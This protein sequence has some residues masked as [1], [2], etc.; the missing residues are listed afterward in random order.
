MNRCSKSAENRAR[1]VP[2]V[3]SCPALRARQHVTGRVLTGIAKA[4]WHKVPSNKKNGFGE[5]I[6]ELG[7]HLHH[8]KTKRHTVLII[9]VAHP[10]DRLSNGDR[11]FVNG[12]TWKHTIAFM[13]AC[14]AWNPTRAL[15]MLS[16]GAFRVKMLR[17]KSA[18]FVRISSE[19][20][21]EAWEQ[22]KKIAATCSKS[23]E[24]TSKLATSE[25]GLW[26]KMK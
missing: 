26:N 24:M 13:L 5:E 4:C 23:Q 9:L 10:L 3:Y 15:R 21:L 11:C 8:W 17:A 12:M 18:N 1:D 6:T 2:V 22:E 25:A 14:S 19:T 16:R 7:C 20:S